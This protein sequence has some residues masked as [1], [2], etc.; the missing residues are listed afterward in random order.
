M[1]DASTSHNAQTPQHHVLSE[2]ARKNQL[3]NNVLFYYIS[4]QS[5]RQRFG[6]NCTSNWG[7]E[8][9]SNSY[10]GTWSSHLMWR[11]NYICKCN[12]NA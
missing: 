5:Y 10:F 2:D 7:I 11:E 12:P 8:K 4:L 9:H 3:D 1:C 6:H